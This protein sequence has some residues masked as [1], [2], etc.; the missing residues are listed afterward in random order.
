MLTADLVSDR[1][2]LQ[3]TTH[4]HDG[5]LKALAPH[6]PWLTELSLMGCKS[7]SGAGIL[8]LLRAS[9]GG[10]LKLALESVPLHG[11][12]LRT[13]AP[14]VS[15][16]RVLALTYP[17]PSI[18]SADYL[19]ALADLVQTLH[20]L[21]SFTFYAPSAAKAHPEDGLNDGD[22]GDDDADGDDRHAGAAWQTAGGGHRSDGL[23][24]NGIP[25]SGPA[26]HTAFL[27]RV[28]SS[29]GAQLRS[30][31]LHGLGM[32]LEQLEMICTSACRTS[33]TDLVV[34]LYEYDPDAQRLSAALSNLAALRD[35]HILTSA[36]ADMIL[37]EQDLTRVADA[38]PTTLRQIGFRHRV[39]MVR[40]KLAVCAKI[41]SRI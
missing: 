20:H 5:V 40:A 25:M 1:F 35:L 15:Q 37:T 7:V 10:M 33:L 18:H 36:H 32:S 21:E 22:D 9:R 12:E 38:C 19:R 34:H 11:D 26:L 4:V 29:R 30:L 2:N 8:A 6:T 3:H 41:K 27:Q 24:P 14:Y 39:W 23:Y 31:R 16:V 28:L 13:L 17:K